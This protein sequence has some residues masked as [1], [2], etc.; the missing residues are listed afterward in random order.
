[1]THKKRSKLLSLLL[2][3]CVLATTS[4]NVLLAKA[5]EPVYATFY[6]V[7]E[8]EF[9]KHYPN[10]SINGSYFKKIGVGKIYYSENIFFNSQK[11]SK[12]IA[13]NPASGKYDWCHAVMYMGQYYVGASMNKNDKNTS[14]SSTLHSLS[15]EQ[16]LSLNGHSYP[17]YDSVVWKDFQK[18]SIDVAD[19]IIPMSLIDDEIYTSMNLPSESRSNC[20]IEAWR[21]NAHTI[22]NTNSSESKTLT[23][24]GAIETTSG[25]DLPE[26]FNVYIGA[27]KMYAYS[28][29]QQKWILID[30]NRYPVGIYVYTLPWTTTKA[31]K[32]SNVTYTSNYAKVTLTKKQL[33]DNCLHFWGKNVSINKNDYL[34]YASSYDFW[35]D[36]S[37]SSKLTASSGIDAKDSAGKKVISQLYSSR[38]YSSQTYKKTVWGTT[39]PNNKYTPEWGKQLQALHDK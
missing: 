37:V 29:S 19:G 30:S 14:Q 32:C 20:M 39:I 16:I 4:K 26:T 2:L 25:Q 3:V 22:G 35:V 33:Q 18:Y 15:R 7:D 6:L 23:N 36:S 1:M 24:F 17:N 21:D 38:G 10:V 11:V 9:L 27:I 5:A 12:C 28:K 8:T 13:E 34:Y 31:T